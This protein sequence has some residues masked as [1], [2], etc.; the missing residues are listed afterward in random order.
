M[1]DNVIDRATGQTL[2]QRGAFGTPVDYADTPVPKLQYQAPTAEHQFFSMAPAPANAQPNATLTGGPRRGSYGD[3]V[4]GS[5]PGDDT[6]SPGAGRMNDP[7]RT[8]F[9]RP[10]PAPRAE[11]TKAVPG[12]V[13]S[14]A[15][16]RAAAALGDSTDP[17]GGPIE[18]A[19]GGGYSK[20]MTTEQANDF[21]GTIHQSQ[22]AKDR[23]DE[24]SRAQ[25]MTAQANDAALSREIDAA[26][27]EKRVADFE[28]K[29]GV[30]PGTVSGVSRNGVA[31]ERTPRGES[32]A[33]LQG[34]Q[35]A[36]TRLD[37]LQSAR[38]A[39]SAA[40]PGNRNYIDEFAKGTPSPLAE[41]EQMQK[42]ALGEQAGQLGALQ[43]AGGNLQLHV[44]QHLSDLQTRASGTGPD[45]EAARNALAFYQKAQ[46]GKGGPLTEEDALKV[47]GDMVS[48]ATSMGGP[49]AYKSLPHF[50]EFF[51]SLH[52]GGA[53]AAPPQGAVDMLKKNPAMREQFDAKY[54]AGASAQILGQ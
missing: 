40:I 12:E 45:A 49:E 24:Q 27:G 31:F 54:G 23:Q 10:A 21:Y 35:E 1:D 50:N 32:A 22:I 53:K 13:Y 16:S 29:Y 34:Q 14:G 46:Q 7:N 37:R 5:N 3:M 2:G 28:A 30:K 4:A 15:I 33:F 19:L 6:G 11:G 20:P 39:N 47:Y 9:A 51:A 44:Q 38:L 18:S 26:R 48:R 43:L 8:Y 36:D 17:H 25:S 42:I 52:G 41:R